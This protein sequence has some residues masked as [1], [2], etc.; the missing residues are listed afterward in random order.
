MTGFPVAS[1]YHDVTCTSPLYGH[2]IKLYQPL[3]DAAEALNGSNVVSG[4]DLPLTNAIL[5]S[6]YN[7]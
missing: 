6:T 2:T 7:S 1:T 3:S 5:S 4:S